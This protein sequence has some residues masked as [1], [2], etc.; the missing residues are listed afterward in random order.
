MKKNKINNLIGLSLFFLAACYSS[1]SAQAFP[2]NPRLTAQT[3]LAEPYISINPDYYYPFE[4]VLYIEGHSDSNSVVTIE[5]RKQGNDLPV[6][7]TVKADSSG[8]WVVVDKTYLSSGIWEVR[9]KQQIGTS[10]SGWSNPRVIRSVVTGVN[11]LGLN[12]RYV[13][14]ATI[15]F[16]FLGIIIALLIYFRRKAKISNNVYTEKLEN[17]KRQQMEQQ[18]QQTENRF[19]EGIAE[20]RKDLMNEL[21]NMAAYAQV[22]P[23]TPDEIERRDH[24]LSELENLEKNFEHDINNIQKKY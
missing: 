16:V 8:E 9:A 22:R 1:V 21:K 18:I 24:I 17:L 10:V 11:I 14:I 7:F 19:H 20:I 6:K 5:L 12:I 13:F 23:L 4:E 3:Q 15:A 2:S